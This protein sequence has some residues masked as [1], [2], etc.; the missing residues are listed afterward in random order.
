MNII[1]TF[2]ESVEVVREKDNYIIICDMCCVH[3][4]WQHL[5]GE[6]VDRMMFD[7]YDGCV[8]LYRYPSDDTQPIEYKRYNLLID[9]TNEIN[10]SSPII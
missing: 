2:L 9:L 8:V 4:K 5:L 6:T 1:D 10:N 3:P 7:L